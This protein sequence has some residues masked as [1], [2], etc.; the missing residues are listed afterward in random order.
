[1]AAHA[2]SMSADD[3]SGKKLYKVF[4]TATSK[5]QTSNSSSASFPFKGF[6]ALLLLNM[7]FHYQ[8][9]YRGISYPIQADKNTFI[10]FNQFQSTSANKTVAVAYAKA[11]PQVVG[12]LFIMKG[13]KLANYITPFSRFPGEDEFLLSP[14]TEFYIADVD[15]T[16]NPAVVTLVAL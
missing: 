7:R 15:K 8:D 14:D 12:T 5:Q 16:Q 4:N 2:Y 11:N 10:R 1:M 6:Y 3:F 9:T 13:R